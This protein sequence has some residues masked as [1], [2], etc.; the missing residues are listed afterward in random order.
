MG[1]EVA[2]QAH[3]NQETLTELRT[4][5]VQILV[6]GPKRHSER[7]RKKLLDIEIGYCNHARSPSTI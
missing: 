6:H 5:N 2:A 7:A 1:G 3:G 4:L